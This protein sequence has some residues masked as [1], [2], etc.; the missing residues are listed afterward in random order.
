M[1]VQPEPLARLRDRLSAFL[2]LF[3]RGL[4]SPREFGDDVPLVRCVCPLNPAL[5]ELERLLS[6]GGRTAE[7]NGSAFRSWKRQAVPVAHA[8]RWTSVEERLPGLVG[9]ARQRD[10]DDHHRGVLRV[11]PYLGL[12]QADWFPFDHR[13]WHTRLA[14]FSR[15]SRG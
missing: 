7:D 9:V 12:T 5:G 4:N 10:V 15:P 11:A 1:L 3:V 13:V 6:V 14:P 8:C 2:G